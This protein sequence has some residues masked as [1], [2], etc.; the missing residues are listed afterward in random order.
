MPLRL[1]DGLGVA[2]GH[3]ALAAVGEGV[4][5]AEPQ[6]GIGPQQLHGVVPGLRRRRPLLGQRVRGHVV[7]AQLVLE[8]AER[9][10]GQRGRVL[11]PLAEHGL[12]VVHRRSP[13][14][15]LHVVPRRVLAVLLG[16]RLRLRVAGVVGVVAAVVREVDAADE[17]DV[18]RSGRRGAA[19][20]GT[21]GGASRPRAPACRAA[22]RRPAPAAARR[23]GGSR[24]RR[25]RWRRG[26][27][28]TRARGRRR[29]ARRPTEDLD[30]L[31][32]RLAGEALVRVA[33]PVGEEHEVTGPRRLDHLVQAA[34]SRSRRGSGGAPGCRSTSGLVAARA[35]RRAA[36]R[37]CPA[38]TWS[39]ATRLVHPHTIPALATPPTSTRVRLRRSK[40]IDGARLL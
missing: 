17:R 8:P 39:A 10:A 24:W 23:G 7:A 31:A 19:R 22:P 18:P 20:R 29:R 35:G 11:P 30:D 36:C 37:C 1:R 3:A 21:S 28:A 34:R 14:L 16:E 32:A 33:L 27:S 25:S 15:D 5:P 4:V 12:D 2:A 38:R 40:I 9:V 26:A 6:V 13:D